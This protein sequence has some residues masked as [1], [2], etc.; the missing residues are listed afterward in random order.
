[1]W[2][3]DFKIRGV[4]VDACQQQFAQIEKYTTLDMSFQLFGLGRGLHPS[5]LLEPHHGM[6]AWHGLLSAKPHVKCKIV[7]PKATNLIV[8]NNQKTIISAEGVISAETKKA[9]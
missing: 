6:V 1:M 3:N 9:E 2:Y 5:K 8:C 7:G 4:F